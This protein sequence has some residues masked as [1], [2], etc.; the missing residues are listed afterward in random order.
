MT[1]GELALLD[2]APRSA[3]VRADQAVECY[4]LSAAAFERLG[5]TH[6]EL[7]IRLLENLL[8][9]TYQMVSALNV[10][11]AALAGGRGVT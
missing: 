11:V 1:F 6:P 7:K 8:R 4:V 10:E 5:E 2:R 3:D 9:G